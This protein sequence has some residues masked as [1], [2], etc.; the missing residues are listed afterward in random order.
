[1][2]AKDGAGGADP[3]HPRGLRRAASSTT[4]RP[5]ST[6]NADAMSDAA[7][8]VVAGEVTRA[9]RD[10]TCDVGPIG[11]GDYLGIARARDPRRRRATVGGAT[12]GLLD[13]LL[14]RRARDRHPD[15]GR[16]RHGRRHPPDHR[17]AGASTAPTWRS[18][19]TTA[20]SRCTPT[21]RRRVSAGR[22]PI[23][24]PPSCADIR[25]TELTVGAEAE[26]A[27][28]PAPS[29]ASTRCSTS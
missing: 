24:L 27:R 11:E 17:V 6:R 21:P 13:E 4:P 1:M 12:I 19:S 26:E 10:S 2:T 29:S 25:V 22:G 3:G 15:R 16:R 20:A 9:V 23:T 8:N 7:A 18:R 5:T 28:G 14:A